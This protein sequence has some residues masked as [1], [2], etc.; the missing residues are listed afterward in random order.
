M[1]IQTPLQGKFE[2]N[3]ETE[4][5]LLDCET[6]ER[7]TS[8]KKLI[9]ACFALTFTFIFLFFLSLFCFFFQVFF[10]SLTLSLS[11][12]TYIFIDFLFSFH[13][14]ENCL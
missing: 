3:S 11:L 7:I 8:T 10:V 12:S 5:F 9:V 4:H 14:F 13:M 2:N 6:N 1:V